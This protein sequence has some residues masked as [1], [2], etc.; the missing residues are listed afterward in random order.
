MKYKTDILKYEDENSILRYTKLKEIIFI[1][2]CPRQIYY[3]K[4]M[5]VLMLKPTPIRLPDFYTIRRE[6]IE[7]KYL[8]LEN[9]ITTIYPKKIKTLCLVNSQIDELPKKVK[10]L[11]LYGNCKFKRCGNRKI[12]TLRTNNPDL[13]GLLLGCQIDFIDLIKN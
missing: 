2:P 9:C 12:K 10:Y 8:K 13:L 1:I 4:K 3:T 11:E 5:L 7:L 6:Y